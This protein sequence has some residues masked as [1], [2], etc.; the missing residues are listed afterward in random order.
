MYVEPETFDLHLHFLKQY[1]DIL[2]VRSLC[3]RETSLRMTTHDKHACYL[4]FDDGWSDFYRYAFP[5]LVKH[6]V[7]ATVY[8][9]TGF[10]G[11]SKSFWTDRFAAILTMITRQGLFA[12]FREYVIR[13][14]PQESR[15]PSSLP[16]KF[17]EDVLCELKKIDVERI[18]K[19][20][21]VLE[22]YFDLSLS[23]DRNDFL[24]WE[25]IEEMRRSGLVT[26]G[27]HTDS[28]RILT[29]LTEDE[30]VTE[31][32]VSKQ[33]LLEKGAVEKEHISFCYPNG[34]YNSSALRQ[35][36][37]EDYSCAFTTSC[38]WNRPDTPIFELKRVG[39]HQDVSCNKQF[40]AYRIYSALACC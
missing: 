8:L 16:E 39:L 35:L 12:K 36:P 26:F 37:A 11:S 25:Q 29:G 31:L 19:L 38:G 32:Q 17:L 34:N 7:P 18:T 2:P 5:L 28:H 4:T 13:Q 15:V 33:R 14:L 1:F 22:R 30:I 24:S 23:P 3:V 10:I 9:P 40:L 20:L 6:Q 27:S 21:D